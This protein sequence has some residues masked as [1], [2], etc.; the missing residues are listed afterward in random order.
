MVRTEYGLDCYRGVVVVLMFAVHVA[1]LLP[2]DSAPGA[3]RVIF[4]WLSWSEPFIA[5]S[6][7]TL[8]GYGMVL[9][10]S[11]RLNPS[12]W[13]RRIVLRSLRLYGLAIGLFILQFGFAWPD[14]LNSPG[15]LSAIAISNLVC[16]VGLISSRPAKWITVFGVLVA[17]VTYYLDQSGATVS[18]LNA[19]PGGAFPLIAFGCFG[20]L[21]ALVARAQ[22][23]PGLARL[24]SV[25]AIPFLGVLWSGDSWVTT[26][27]S[28]YTD[29]GGQVAALGLLQGLKGTP[30]PLAFWNHSAIGLFGLLLPI[31][32][33]LVGAVFFRPK[34]WANWA[35]FPVVLLGR[36]AL[37]AYVG[38]L[39]LLGLLV[40]FDVEP[41][42]PE[43]GLLLVVAMSLGF[44]GVGWCL[45][46]RFGGTPRSAGLRSWTRPC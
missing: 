42:H 43:A 32:L 26:R 21:A 24:A 41:P 18:G 20:S 2:S 19:G 23:R 17:G 35:T 22:G 10:R 46:R 15:I 38:H 14:L 4:Q 1:R 13:M 28:V 44:A 9:S 39:L 11:R 3:A 16:A 36:H 31:A 33:T 40:A 37:V 25:T 7:L 8:S 45:E 29:Y 27:T 6:F 34:P 5:A 30:S 12:Q